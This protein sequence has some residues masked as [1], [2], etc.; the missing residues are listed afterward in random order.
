M[1][2]GNGSHILLL[3]IPWC[4]IGQF[5]FDGEVAW[6]FLCI[7]TSEEELATNHLL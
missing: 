2:V 1:C 5:C 7:D 6:L 4:Q 3:L